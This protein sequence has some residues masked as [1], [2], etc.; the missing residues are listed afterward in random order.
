MKRILQITKPS[1]S[2][3]ILWEHVLLSALAFTGTFA[4]LFFGPLLIAGKTQSKT[5]QSS[6]S[7]S[8]QDLILYI[9]KHPE[10]SIGLSIF[11]VV[12]TNTY[13]F[14]KNS[15]KHYVVSVELD[16]ENIILGKTNLYYRATETISIPLKQLALQ[17]ISNKSDSGEKKSSLVFLNSEDN[18]PLG[19]INPSH[20]IWSKQINEIRQAIVEIETLGV[21][22]NKLNK[23]R[24]SFIGF[25]FNS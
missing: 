18:K 7:D 20:I 8:M 11:A 23:T 22:K 5:L 15:K 19:C 25:L 17:L 3:H 10:F 14:I 1:S 2:I 9:V 24:R 4:L 21:P 13:L 6:D 12:V 16:N